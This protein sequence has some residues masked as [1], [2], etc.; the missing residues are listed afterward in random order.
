MGALWR[1]DSGST[2]DRK[3]R[4]RRL[5]RP[6]PGR[7]GPRG[8][9]RVAGGV[10]AGARGAAPGTTCSTAGPRRRGQLDEV[11][12]LVEEVNDLLSLDVDGVELPESRLPRLRRRLACHTRRAH[13]LGRRLRHRDPPADGAQGVRSVKPTS[14]AHRPTAHAT[15]LRRDGGRER[16]PEGDP[17]LEAARSCSAATPHGL[18]SA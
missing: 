5:L 12:G 6:Q 18:S 15:W 1:S 9:E 14:R 3:D 11:G 16:P 4:A 10:P 17:P 8:Q 7:P 2:T 13:R